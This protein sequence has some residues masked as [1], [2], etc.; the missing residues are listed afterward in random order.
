MTCIIG[1]RC[2][3]G[4]VLA[5]DRKIVDEYTRDVT[6][7]QKLYQYYYPIVVGSSGHIDPFD[8]FRREAVR[9]AQNITPNSSSDLKS[10]GYQISGIVYTFQTSTD[11]APQKSVLN[12]YPYIEKLSEIIRKYKANYTSYSF[13]VI[14]AAQ[15]QEKRAILEYIDDSGLSS[16]IYDSYKIL[17]YG[18]I[19]ANAFLKSM[20][21]NNISM[22]DFGELCYFIIK[23]FD[24]FEIDYTVGL[25]GMKPQIWFI[26]DNGHVGEADELTLIRYDKNSENIFHNLKQYGI[27]KLYEMHNP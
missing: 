2:S 3:N 10:H 16:D 20:W 12:L 23:Y 21:S 11:A 8:N 19:V 18:N 5:A 24:K 7:R 17:G 25:G 15:T 22:E 14:F 9:A 26:P 13:D 4:V 1:G 27:K 6:Y